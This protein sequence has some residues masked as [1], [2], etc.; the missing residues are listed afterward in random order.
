MDPVPVFLSV[1]P[2]F[3]VVEKRQ[4]FD[5][6]KQVH[7]QLFKN[8]VTGTAHLCEILLQHENC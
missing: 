5:L 1:F 6:K 3:V 8:V 7:Q 4:L 2:C